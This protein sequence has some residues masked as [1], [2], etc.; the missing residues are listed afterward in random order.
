MLQHSVNPLADE[1]SVFSSAWLPDVSQVN[2]ERDKISNFGES[3]FIT[4]N[5]NFYR[6]QYEQVFFSFGSLIPLGG[7]LIRLFMMR[8]FVTILTKVMSCISNTF[9]GSL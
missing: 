2:L 7:P 3:E 4:K 9:N 1:D 8:L 5:L 6:K